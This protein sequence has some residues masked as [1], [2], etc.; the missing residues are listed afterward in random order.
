MSLIFTTTCNGSE[1]PHNTGRSCKQGKN[2]YLPYFWF[3]TSSIQ[4]NKM[5]VDIYANFISLEQHNLTNELVY[6]QKHK[7]KTSKT[8]CSACAYAGDVCILITTCLCSCLCHSENQA[9][10]LSPPVATYRFYSV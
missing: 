2:R 7:N 8:L 10:T 6:I 1:N 3:H 9:L 4:H 5:A